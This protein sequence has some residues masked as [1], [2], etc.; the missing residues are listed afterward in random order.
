LFIAP[1]ANRG[2]IVFVFLKDRPRLIV[3]VVKKSFD[4]TSLLFR[5]YSKGS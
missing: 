4:V 2:F 1:A 3:K 5:K